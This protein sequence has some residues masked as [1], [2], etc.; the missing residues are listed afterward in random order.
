[1]PKK[2]KVPARVKDVTF[3]MLV[4]TLIIHTYWKSLHQLRIV[5][6]ELL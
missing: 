5:N 4:Q 2:L 1:M 3:V 6:E